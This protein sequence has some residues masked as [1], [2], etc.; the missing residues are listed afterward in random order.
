MRGFTAVD[1]TPQC[2][3]RLQARYEYALLEQIDG[4]PEL[5]GQCSAEIWRSPESFDFAFPQAGGR[6]VLRWCACSPTSGI[7][8]L[9][10]E[11]Q[12]FSVS[13][14]ASGL[15]IAADRLT[16]DAC[17]Q[18]FV[19]Q[20]RGTPFE[21]SF[22]LIDLWQRPLVATIGLFLPA[23]DSDKKLF[24]LADRCFAAAYFRRLGLI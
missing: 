19:R 14:L 6:L 10:G 23:D 18:Y 24:A 2:E 5:I 1:L 3:L 16:L 15:D 21:P 20:L 4:A 9:L 11:R 7:A 17:Q 12:A 22:G 8:I 13:L